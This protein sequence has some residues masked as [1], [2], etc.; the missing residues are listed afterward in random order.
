[1]SLNN[2]VTLTITRESVGLRRA[3][4]GT[5]LILSYSAAWA[6]RTREYESLSDVAADFPTTTSPEYL[7]AQALFAQN[8]HPEKLVIGRGALKPTQVYTLDATA[9]DLATY[10]LTAAGDG[11]TETE[12]SY[13]AEAT[14]D[15]GE[16]HYN[17]LTQLNAVVGKNFT[18]TYT[19]LVYA[20][21]TFTA[22]ITGIVTNAAHGL[23]TGDGPFQLTSSGTLPTG[24][25]L[26]TDYWIIK[27]DA[28]T[29]YF[30]SSLA[31][32]FA[33]TFV[34]IS[35]TGSG[36]HTIAD[37]V[38]TVRPSDPLTVTGTAQG[39][40]FSLAVENPALIAIDQTQADPG[41]ATDLT[42]ITLER[43]DWYCL[44]TNFNSSA[45]VNAAANWI[46]SNNRIYLFDAVESLSVTGTDGSN[47]VIDDNQTAGRSRVHA[48]FYNDP[49]KMLSASHAGRC[50][51]LN[52]GSESWSLKRLVGPGP[53]S[54]TS[55]Q[56]TNLTNKYGNSYE[57]VSPGIYITFNGMTG[58]GD[59]LDVQRGID[60]MDDDIRKSIME[61]LI[62]NNK[63]IFN[64]A[65]I[66]TVS[67]GLRGS[68]ERAKSR[69]II[70]DY[71]IT[72]PRFADISTADRSA[73][74]LSGLSFAATLAG[75][76]HKV[77]VV[78]SISL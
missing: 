72:V 47:D 55:T 23:L 24:L 50:L 43:A 42:A 5:A 44:L 29:H 46:Q 61:V 59:Y 19:P 8:P 48:A 15:Q 12:I 40:W 6:E 4:F 73:R 69:G 37:T 60:W 32:A 70:L 53:V 18:A 14:A 13:A 33:G 63:I 1:M 75:A 65:G 67:S 26:A 16:I 62:A 49:S 45:M 35:G 54:L 27:I 21:D 71:T 56:R 25:A 11:V 58:D 7:A 34:T 74:T 64:D 31:N 22:A 17:L 66:R 51:P 38:S 57:E 3:G 30:A 28:N 77:N 68:L 2:F 76:I 36:T 52:P 78:G 10:N 41:I 39:E 20:D 9:T